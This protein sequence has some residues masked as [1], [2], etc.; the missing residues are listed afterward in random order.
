MDRPFKSKYG[1]VS[2]VL[3]QLVVAQNYIWL[4]FGSSHKTIRKELGDLH[5]K[6]NCLKSRRPYS[7]VLAGDNIWASGLWGCLHDTGR[8]SRRDE[9]TPVPSH[10]SIFVYMIP[11]QKVM[12]A[13]V[14]P[15]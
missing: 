9:F 11:P 1:T 15:A 10:G 7:N 8:L 5:P 2:Q 14:T 3:L 12:P 6:L 13:R 4:A